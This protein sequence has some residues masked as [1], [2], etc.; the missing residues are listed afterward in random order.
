MFNHKHY[1]PILKG[2]QGEYGALQ[3]IPREVKSRVVPVVEIPPIPWDF[4]EEQPDKTVDQHLQGIGAKLERAWGVEAPMFVDLLWIAEDARMADGVHPLTYVFGAARERGLQVIPVT[5]LVRGDEYQTA[6]RE[7]ISRDRRGVCL[8]LQREDFDESQDLVQQVS[9]LLNALRVSPSDADLILDLRALSGTEGGTLMAAVPALIR[10]VPRLNE[11]RAFALAAT[12]FPENLAGLPPSELSSLP[13]LEWV[14]WRNLVSRSRT[15]RLPA[16]SDYGIAHVQPSEVDP[17]VMRPS[18]SIRYTTD[19]TWLILKGRNLRDHGYP[20]FHDVS[21][22]LVRRPEYN[23]PEFSWG[24]QYVDDCANERVGTGN[25]TTWRKVG[26]SHHL[27]FV[28]SQLA[29]VAWP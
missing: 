17:R 21:R 14:L 16:F 3:T 15:L 23:G 6:C 7:I 18:A 9:D 5:G 24:D 22:F 4:A 29:S 28:L 12:A 2:R 20:Q 1:V 27:A 10:N 13:R 26:T 11:W 8:R 19:E 25:L